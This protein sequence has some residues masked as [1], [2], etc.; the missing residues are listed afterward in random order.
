V[1]AVVEDYRS[2]LAE[3]KPPCTSLYQ[4]THRHRPD[5]DQDAIRFRNLVATAGRS[6]RRGYS[7]RETRRLLEPL[8]AL[9]EDTAFWN[10]TF[11]GLAVFR[12]ND[13]MRTYRLQ[14]PVVELVVV[15][16]S[17]HTRPLI[18][19]LQSADRYQVLAL[20]LEKIRLFEGNRDTLDE[21][22]LAAGVPR[23]MADALGTE[24]T[25]PHLTVASYGGVGSP[26]RRHGHGARKDEVDVDRERFFGAVGSAVTKHHSRVA[27]L[28]LVLA[29]LPQHQSAF[30]RISRNPCLLQGE[31]PQTRTR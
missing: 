11:D 3:A 7:V 25:E 22:E 5:N 2:E 16:D 1:N 30:R 4:P 28:P 8:H 9:A 19:I 13:R 31:S 12:D 15:A 6:L 10:N 17:F 21:V 14:R 24:L 29:A 27:D 20:G 26:A 23:T 18:R